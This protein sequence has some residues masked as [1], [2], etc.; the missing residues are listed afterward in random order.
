[1]LNPKTF[2]RFFFLAIL[3]FPF[4]L[5]ADGVPK[6]NIHKG[7]FYFSWG[8]NKGW[9]S[10]SD[11]HF[12]EKN[13]AKNYDFTVYDVVAHDSPLLGRIMRWDV[14]IP[15]FIYRFGYYFNDSRD[16]GIEIGFDHAKYIVDRDQH[17]HIKGSI[18]GESI[19]KD[20]IIQPRFLLFEHTNGA[21]FL[22]ASLLKRISFYRSSN[23]KHNIAVVFKPGAG[24]V[25]PRTDVTLFGKRRDNIYH[26]AGYI[27]GLETVLRYQY[28]KHWF[29]E[30]GAKGAYANYLNV[31]TV[32]D[33]KA[34]HHFYSFEC[35]FSVGYGFPW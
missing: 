12:S 31:L 13:T 26:I 5:F 25:I 9:F 35:L 10:K 33:A 28:G 2:I 23:E 4:Y 21:N 17:V 11:L 32:G 30:G 29:A 16:L 6:P 22:M 24:I 8:Y 1:M 18:Y 14:T 20:T 34:S 7:T 15:Q 3:S 19:D 27:A